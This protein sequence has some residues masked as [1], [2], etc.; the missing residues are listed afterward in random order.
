VLLSSK[1]Y[2]FHHK[3]SLNRMII[4]I[5][6]WIM[7]VAILKTIFNYIGWLYYLLIL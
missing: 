1:R 3:K 6:F 4:N 7:V 5:I 2:K